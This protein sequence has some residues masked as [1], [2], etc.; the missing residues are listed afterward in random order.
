VPLRVAV[1]LSGE[2]TSLENL[3]EHIDAGLPA[4]VEVVIASKPRAGG[5]ARA[6]RRG[7][8]ALAVSRL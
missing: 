2:G 8:P 6:A 3:F 4:R 7:V 1:L 5:L